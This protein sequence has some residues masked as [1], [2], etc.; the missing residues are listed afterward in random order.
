M[1]L[2]GLPARMRAGLPASK[3]A[4]VRHNACSP[5]A[6]AV[7]WPGPLKAARFPPRGLSYCVS[8]SAG[9]PADLHKA[10][11]HMILASSRIVAAAKR[12]LWSNLGKRFSRFLLVAMAAVAA[13]QITLTICL[14][15][16]GLTAGKSALAAWVAGASVSYVLSRWAWERKGKPHLMKETLPFWVVAVGT[17]I[18]LTSTVKFANHQA[19][20]MGLGHAQRVL[21]ADAAYFLANSVTFMTRFVIFH[22]LLFADRGSKEPSPDAV[23]LSRPSATAPANGSEPESVAV[24]ESG[25]ES[26]AVNGS[27]SRGSGVP[28]WAGAAERSPNGRAEPESSALPEPGMRL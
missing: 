5:G 19:L 28:A 12:R 2:S 4:A 11:T 6:G 14:G 7:A 23:E 10:R 3:R 20:Q 21:F 1:D 16:V 27:A 8:L 9:Q 18:V 26:A 24:N 13:S 15:P 22:Y 25:P 17:A